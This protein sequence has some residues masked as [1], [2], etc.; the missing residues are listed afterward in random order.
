MYETLL[1]SSRVFRDDSKR[2]PE[3][4]VEIDLDQSFVFAVSLLH[5]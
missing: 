4:G 2:A 3:V 1:V 5:D